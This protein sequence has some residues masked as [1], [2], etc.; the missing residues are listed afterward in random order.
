MVMRLV[1]M[2]SAQEAA[3]R[4]AGHIAGALREAIAARGSATLALSGGGAAAPLCMALTSENLNWSAIDVFQVDERVAPRGD[5]ARNL[6]TIERNLG[7]AGP[8]PA[9][10][11]A[12]PVDAVDL[13]AAAAA[14]EAALSGVAGSSPV[15][16]VVHLGLGGD[17]HTASLFPGDPATAIT[18]RSVAVTG[19][20]AG[21]RRMTLTLPVLSN[22]RQVVW[23]VTGA[24]KAAVLADLVAGRLA[25]P[26]GQVTRARAVVF[27]DSDAGG[28]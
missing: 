25:T 7:G 12:M 6:T 13:A 11:H 3:A 18:D 20:H 27:A 21:F 14:Y 16:D 9:R 26:A 2:P 10:V 23:L 8:F 19:S 17:G 15:L 22:A 28:S 5:P 1:V 4:A 24:A